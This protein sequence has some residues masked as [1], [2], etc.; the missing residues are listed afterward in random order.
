MT[1]RTTVRERF[2]ARTCKSTERRK[3]RKVGD[4]FLSQ[5]VGDCTQAVGE[6]T[7]MWIKGKLALQSSSK[8]SSSKSSTIKLGDEVENSQSICGGGSFFNCE[9]KEESMYARMNGS[10]HG[11][12]EIDR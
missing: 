6:C 10:T 4:F 9:N 12:V 2:E 1:S 7:N 3:Q 11:L 8:R 5:A